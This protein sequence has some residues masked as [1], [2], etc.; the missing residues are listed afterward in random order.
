[1]VM[2]VFLTSVLAGRSAADLD[3]FSIEHCHIHAL[4]WEGEGSWEMLE[5]ADAT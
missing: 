1:M 3:I 5:E 2:R 4:V